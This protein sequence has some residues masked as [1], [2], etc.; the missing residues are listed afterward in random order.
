MY[1]LLLF[2]ISNEEIA[3]KNFRQEW[4]EKETRTAE[5]ENI[6]L[7]EINKKI[8]GVKHI[9]YLVITEVCL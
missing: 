6:Q 1:I 4:K 3:N 9:G 8:S 5:T 2:A 7:R